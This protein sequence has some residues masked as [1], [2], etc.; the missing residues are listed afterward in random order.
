MDALQKF[1]DHQSGKA[2]IATVGDYVRAAHQVK[3]HTRAHG[4]RTA[5]DSYLASQVINNSRAMVYL[6]ARAKIDMT[7]SA[8][9]TLQRFNH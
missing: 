4:H 2:V 6:V 5:A 8:A 3:K 9:E 1:R 7:S